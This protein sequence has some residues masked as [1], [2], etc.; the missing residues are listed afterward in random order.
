MKVE[1]KPT[2]I[3]NKEELTALDII[4]TCLYDIRNEHD[5]FYDI[6]GA[7]TIIH[8]FEELTNFLT[9]LYENCKID[10]DE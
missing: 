4:C 2:L 1:N 10:H 7:P 8:D 6:F 3:V 9:V 5:L